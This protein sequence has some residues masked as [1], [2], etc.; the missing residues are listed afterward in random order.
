MP[1]PLAV[2]WENHKRRWLDCKA[3]DLC[4]RRKH[5]VLLRGHIPAPILFVGEA[6]GTSEDVLGKPFKG[7]AGQL[8]DRIIS[9]AGL[10]AKDY[11]MTNII[12]C[13]PLVEIETS[14][15]NETPKLV[16]IS[17]PPKYAVEACRPRLDECL[18]LVKPRV[19][20]RVGAEAD[21][22]LP[23][24]G[25]Y[26][27]PQVSILHPGNIIRLPVVSR[28]LAVQ[29]TVIRVSEALELVKELK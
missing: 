17:T 13:I 25:L 26:D 3:C 28:P 5:V 15:D 19:I 22:Y 4:L 29:R 20:V 27:V 18:R 21:K 14:F 2:T 23:S 9:L 7:P 1:K 12:A 11:A 16:K 24:G 6:P 8:F 10:G